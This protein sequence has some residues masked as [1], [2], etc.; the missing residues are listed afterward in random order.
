[1]PLTYDFFRNINGPIF[2]L[3][4]IPAYILADDAD[5]EQLNAGKQQQQHDDC[6]IPRHSNAPGQLF[7]DDRN[8][9][10]NGGNAADGAKE[11]GQPQR[12]SGIADDALHGIVEELPEAPLC[13]AVG[14]LTGGIG[15]E[16]GGIAHPG[17]DALGEA[18]VFGKLQDAVPYA[19]A[20]GPEIAGVRLQ[21][22]LGQLIDDLIEALLEEGEDLSLVAPVLI[23]GYNVVFRFFIQDV[24]HI[25]NDFRPLLQ[26]R[27]DE[28]DVFAG[29][30]LQACVNAG[31]L[32]EI[33][34]EGHNFYPAVLPGIDFFQI[35]QRCV[36][37][38]VVNVDDLDFIPAAPKGIQGRLMKGNNVLALI[39][40]GDHQRKL[41]HRGYT[42]KYQIL[43]IIA[44][45]RPF[46]K[47]E[48]GFS[49]KSLT[50]S[51]YP[52]RISEMQTHGTGGFPKN[53]FQRGR[54][55]CERLEPG[56]EW[57]PGSGLAETQEGE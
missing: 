32:A 44:T 3:L 40:A 56:G 7:N 26:I 10:N 33:P 47:K 18:V 13:G 14:T 27:I 41:Y 8:Q 35:V 23:G 25:P 20:E 51:Q 48:Q 12:R 52:G 6:C 46:V 2:A 4:E 57:S 34:G 42:P 36:P 24:H 49:K 1:M 53:G 55:W 29:G 43:P 16:A 19:A 11:G 39:V 37:T 5:A 30:V 9:I 54:G 45:F 28:A 17:E 38:A 50:F 22:N 21:G 15:D 31:L